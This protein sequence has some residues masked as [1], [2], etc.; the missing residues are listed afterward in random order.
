MHALR[1]RAIGALLIAAFAAS[2]NASPTGE[3]LFADL[4]H[5]VDIRRPQQALE[6]LDRIAKATANLTECPLDAVYPTADGILR[7]RLAFGQG[8]VQH[9]NALYTYADIYF[10]DEYCIYM[11][12]PIRKA[13][14]LEE[15]RDFV[16]SLMIEIP[17]TDYL[18][19]HETPESRAA[20]ARTFDELREAVHSGKAEP[21]DPYIPPYAGMEN[22]AD[23]SNTPVQMLRDAPRGGTTAFIYNGAYSWSDVEVNGR[24]CI[25]LES[26][27]NRGLTVPEARDFLAATRLGMGLLEPPHHEKKEGE[28]DPSEWIQAEPGAHPMVPRWA[29]RDDGPFEI[30]IAPENESAPQK[31]RAKEPKPL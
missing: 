22:L 9:Y 29:T 14:T 30:T 8:S 31:K 19:P 20:A 13:L 24:S 2:A 6:T 7:T 26:P 10:G 25:Y 27:L 18:I 5:Q 28:D 16:S 23:C 15:A 1:L 21:T 4:R 11:L 12:K 17:R 3:V